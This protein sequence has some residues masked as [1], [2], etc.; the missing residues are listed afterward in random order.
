MF[1]T[2][3]YIY[4]TYV[5]GDVRRGELLLIVDDDV[6]D[7]NFKQQLITVNGI[8]IIYGEGFFCFVLFVLFFDLFCF[9]FFV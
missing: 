2:T 5:C 6:L 9:V 8:L 1:Q 7:K 4:L 3:Y